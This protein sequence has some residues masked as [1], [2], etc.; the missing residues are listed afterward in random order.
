MGYP[1]GLQTSGRRLGLV[2]IFFDKEN[3]KISLSL[4]LSLYSSR[5]PRLRIPFFLRP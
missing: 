1:D 5:N 2:S 4:S 3:I